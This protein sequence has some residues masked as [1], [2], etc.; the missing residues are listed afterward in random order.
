D[1]HADAVVAA[2][3]IL[4]HAGVGLGIVKVGVGIE[5]AQDARNGAI[6]DGRLGLVAGDGL[7]VVLVNERIYIGERLE[8]VAK[9]AL[10]CGGLSAHIALQHAAN[11]S[12][13]AEEEN[14]GEECATGAG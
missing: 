6:V 2:A 3:L 11:D 8:V 12:A 9:L 1:D 7:S 5:H 14:Y 13:D 4:A 10:V